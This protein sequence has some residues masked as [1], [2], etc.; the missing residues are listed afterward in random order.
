MGLA[1]EPLTHRGET[2]ASTDKETGAIATTRATATEREAAA[3]S[4][5]R[6]GE[7]STETIE[8]GQR[9]KAERSRPALSDLVKNPP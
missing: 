4:E 9:K 7:A 1:A 5:A 3:T 6:C 8:A 2:G